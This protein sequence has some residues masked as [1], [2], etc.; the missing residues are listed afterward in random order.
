MAVVDELAR[1]EH[2]RHEFRAIDHRVEAALQEADQI[3]AR[4]AAHADRL[5]VIFAELLFR[6]IAVIAFELLLRLQLGAEIGELALAALAVLAGAI[7]APVD[8]AFRTAP[9]ILA[10]AAVDFILRFCALRHRVSSKTGLPAMRTRERTPGAS[11]QSAAQ[12][13]RVLPQAGRNAPSSARP[14]KGRADRRSLRLKV[15]SLEGSAAGAFGRESPPQAMR[16][17]RRRKRRWL[18][19]FRPG[20]KGGGDNDLDGTSRRDNIDAAAG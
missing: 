8:R 13:L 15:S 9:D 1:G 4:V 12:R 6:N 18:E 11:R 7:F 2:R 20:V 16:A 17:Q 3:V 19:E 5:G 10:H 14:F